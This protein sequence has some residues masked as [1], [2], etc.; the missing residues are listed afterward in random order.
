MD[1]FVVD[2]GT[3][4]QGEVSVSGSKN[5]ALPI[6]AASLLVEG[7]VRLEGVPDLRD[8]RTMLRLLK[9]LGC[10][11]E[12]HDDGSLTLEVADEAP[13][14][15]PYD[16]V[17]LMRASFCVLGPLLARRGRARV[18]M[19]GGCNLGVRPVD[20]HLKGLRA[21]GA[22]L[23]FENGYVY[24]NG[25]LRGDEI[26]LAGAFGSTVLGTANVMMAAVLAEGRT[27]IEGAACE[28]EVADLA[29]FLIACGAR[30]EGIGSHRL[31]IDGVAR[32][33]G[34]TWRVISDRMEAGTLMA[35]AAI[36]RGDVMIRGADPGSMGAVI[37]AVKAMGAAVE[38]STEGIRVVA[39]DRP[40]PL[41][42]T[43]LPYPGFPTDLQAPFVSVL[44]VAD[45]MSVVTERIYPERIMH[46]AELNRMG[47]EVRKQGPS[48]I[49]HGVPAL[50]GAEVMASDLRGGAALVLAAL[51][52]RGS[53]QVHRIYHTDRG[54]ERLEEKL[55]RLGARIRRIEED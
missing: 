6:L 50:R 20:L 16:I 47:G 9:E 18:S 7:E 12:R 55:S 43:T 44:S 26:F 4:L 17:K 52:A 45:G 31:V 39:Q 49:V 11:V 35:A 36:T 28:P 10:A 40:Q 2:G 24:G 27:V 8:I 48:Q 54:Y 19:P 51:A 5:A 22:R 29:R 1:S 21:L 14:T 15:A 46:V 53:T 38:R 30:I 41:D 23:D 42:L 3:A 37:E 13:D 33:Q 32:L 25:P 34:T